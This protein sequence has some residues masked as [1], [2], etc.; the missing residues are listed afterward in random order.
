[1]HSLTIFAIFF[2][3]AMHIWKALDKEFETSIGVMAYIDTS[4]H[5]LILDDNK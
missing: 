1:M 4:W 3:F 2:N 5:N